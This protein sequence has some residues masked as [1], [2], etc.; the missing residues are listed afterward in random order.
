MR[1]TFEYAMVNRILAW[2]DVLGTQV[3]MVS[4]QLLS[5]PGMKVPLRRVDL[6]ES[7]MHVEML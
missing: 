5:A 1:N 4:G 6:L 3:Y 7:K 2:L